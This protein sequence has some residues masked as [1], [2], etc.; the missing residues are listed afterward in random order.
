[1]KSK[2]LEAFDV[3]REN[4]NISKLYA[5][6]S[7]S[8]GCMLAARLAEKGVKFTK[9]ELGGWDYHDAI[10]TDLPAKAA[11]L[12]K[13]L[14]ALLQHL[15]LKGL[16]DSTLVVVATE[17]GRSPM[18]NPNAGKTI[19]QMVLHVSWLG[20]VKA[21][22]VYGKMSADGKGQLIMKLISLILTQQ[23]AGLWESTQLNR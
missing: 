6:D 3:S 13:G 1:M 22:E 11:M 9:V 18:I 21:G 19:G 10:Y 15:A 4:K 20:R 23:L 8:Q 12:D 5:Q 7:F 2:D 16:L 17:F 14:S